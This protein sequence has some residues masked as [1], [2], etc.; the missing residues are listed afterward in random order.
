MRVIDFFDRGAWLAP[1]KPCLVD[2]ARSWTYRE[3]AAMTR[4]IANALRAVGLQLGAKIA[5]LSPNDIRGF[6]AVLGIFRADMVWVTVNARNAVA[7]NLYILGW[8]DAEFLFYHSEFE[9]QVARIRAELPQIAH[10]VCI[11]REGVAAPSLEAWYAPHPDHDTPLI[12][13]PDTVVRISSTGGTTGYPKGVMQTNLV[14]TTVV[15]NV[16]AVMHYESPPVFLCAAPMT[17]AAGFMSWATFAEGG[18][19]V[20]IQKADPLHVLESIPRHRVTTALL[21]PTLLYMM[22]AHPRLREFDYSSLRYLIYGTAPM[23]A[24]KLREA[25]AAFGPVMTQLFGQ[26]E[27]PMTICYMSPRDHDVLGDPARERRLLSAGRPMPFTQLAIMD[28]KGRL[29]PCGEMGEVVLRGNGRMAGYYRNPDATEEVS[30]FGWHHTG[31]IGWQDDD[32]FVYLVDR[33]KDMIVSG[34]FNVYPSEVE[35]VIWSHPGVQDCAVIGVPDEK[36]GE[37]VKA[38]IEAKPNATVEPAEIIAMCKAELGSVKA[39]KTVEVWEAL[40]RSA[41]GKV[42]KRKIRERYWVGRARAI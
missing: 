26:T 31:D 10:F 16:L 37:A 15:A 13:G 36:W 3:T 25:I 30:R 33:K 24:D 8:H 21:P 11:D 17:H 18:T 12:S 20:I 7:E 35:R 19:L 28:D 14:F 41:V 29:L 9:E 34:G 27:F 5:V 40:P 39:P 2:D 42:L 1:D 4:R 32:G 38:V 23:S 22:L 6:A